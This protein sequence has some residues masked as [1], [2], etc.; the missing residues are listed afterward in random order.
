MT[1]K[2]TRLLLLYICLKYIYETE[3]NHCVLHSA[4]RAGREAF[5]SR[6]SEDLA[7]TQGH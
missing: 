4:G 1:T 2:R 3:T 5:E 7:M 6:I